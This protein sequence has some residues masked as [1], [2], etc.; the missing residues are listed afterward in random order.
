MSNGINLYSKISELPIYIIKHSSTSSASSYLGIEYNKIIIL[1]QPPRPAAVAH[2]QWQQWPS[3]GAG[4]CAHPP[5]G[6][7]DDAPEPAAAEERWPGRGRAGSQVKPAA[8]TAGNA[9]GDSGAT[10]PIHCKE[11][12]CTTRYGASA[13]LRQS[14]MVGGLFFPPHRLPSFSNCKKTVRNTTVLR[15]SPSFPGWS[16]NP[17]CL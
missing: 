13:A 7:T 15:V 1:A 6:Y 2:V 5:V 17:L 14:T 9:A 11:A 12:F 8:R 3:L 4:P 10:G 16:G